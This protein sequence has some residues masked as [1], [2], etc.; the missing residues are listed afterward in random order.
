M[1]SK[2]L[3]RKQKNLKTFWIRGC[4]VSLFEFCLC[5]DT[6]EMEKVFQMT[7]GWQVDLTN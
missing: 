7:R 2:V 1:N 4:C 3:G 5:S 6:M